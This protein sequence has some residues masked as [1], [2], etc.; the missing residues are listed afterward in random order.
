VGVTTERKGLTMPQITLPD[1]SQRQYDNPVSVLEIATDIGPG[2]A[3]AAL[4]GAIDNQLVDIS[5]VLVADEQLRIITDKDPEGLEIIR[6]SCAHLM[7]QAV[8]RLYPE[9]QVT[10]GPVIEDGFFYDFAYERPFTPEDLE[11]IEAK[12]F[13][14]AK[15]DLQVTRKILSRND[16]VDFFRE[17]GEDYKAQIIEVIPENEELSLYQ[18]GEFTDLC[19]GPHVPNTGKLKAFKLTKLAGAYWRGDSRNEMLQ[20]IYGTAWPDKK[21][22]RQYLNRLAE[23]EKR[24]HRKIARKLDLLH[25]QEEAPG[26]VFWHEKGWTIY[27]II[28]N[29]IRDRVEDA[30]YQ[31]IHT[32]L[33]I[34]RILWEK[35]GHISKFGDDMF[36]TNSEN[37]EYAIKPMNCPAHI[38]IFNQ[39]MKSYRDLPLRMAEF[40]ACHR[41]ELSG[42]LHGLMRARGFTQDDAH[43]FCRENQIQEEVTAFMDLLFSVYKDFGFEEIIIKLSTR[44]EQR[45]G[46]DDIWDKAEKALE[47]ALNAMDLQW[48]L[49]PGE[50]AFYG[51]KIEFSLKDSIGRIWQCGTIQADFSMP[52]RLG[53]SYIDENSQ[54]QT[55]VMLHRAILG[56][57]ERFIGILIENY[58]GSFP[59]WL[60]P[61]QAVVISISDNQAEYVKLISKTLKKQGFRVESDLRNETIGLK[62]REHAMQRIPYQIIVGAK[63]VEMNTVAVRTRD[64]EDLGAIDLGIFIE[65]LNKDI[66]YRGCKT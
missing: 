54:K 34:D 36:M 7:A 40:G 11:A 15:E 56:S 51:P 61:I 25:F 57:M 45:V 14:I 32:P 42:A 6:H 23:A 58:A 12:M 30:G 29:Y 60:S 18:Q 2:L 10:I 22:L 20:R 39:G 17:L 53:A 4:A 44:P 1:G 35:S 52:G 28:E 19:R 5:Y 50:G 38:Q 33:I 43:I 48:V 66:A 47:L 64:G 59:V 46:N 65:R 26:M 27:R 37:R 41:N 24:D 9:A 31:E 3:R 55:P 16:A 8:K 62:I 49:Q 13:E 63:E 21:I